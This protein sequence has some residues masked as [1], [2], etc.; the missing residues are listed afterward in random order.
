MVLQKANS[1]EQSS[2]NVSY[3]SCS[4]NIAP[5]DVYDDDDLTVQVS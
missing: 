3:L 4:P 2:E 5:D 1:D